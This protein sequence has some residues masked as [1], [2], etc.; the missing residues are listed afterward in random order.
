MTIERK[1][2]NELFLIGGILLLVLLFYAGN[3]MM[4][5]NNAVSA[6]VSVE[7]EVFGNYPLSKDLNMV[8]TGYKG[9]TNH[10]VIKD[11]EAS[12]IEASCPDKVCVHQGVAKEP[13]QPLVCLPN[14]VIV[15][16]K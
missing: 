6:E 3:R 9:G 7:G 10:L 11:G 12:I 8:I 13:G 1:K 16:I 2:R 15:T 14:K 4:F 5:G